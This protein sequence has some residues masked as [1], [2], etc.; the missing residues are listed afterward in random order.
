VYGTTGPT[1]IEDLRDPNPTT[2]AFLQAA[3]ELGWPPIE[4]NDPD[5]EGA[6][7]VRVTQHRGRRWSAADAYLEPARRR[8]NLRIITGAMAQRVV[9]TS[10]RAVGVEVARPGEGPMVVRAGAEVILAAGAVGSPHLLMRSGIGDPDE[11]RSLGIDVVAPRAEVGRNLQDHLLV[12]VV[13]RTPRPVSLVTAKSPRN[14]ARFL[15]RGRGPLT[16]N[17]GEALALLRTSPDEPAPDL[18]LIW[19]PVPFIDHGQVTP[20]G[21]GLTVGVALLQ[22]QSR[23]RITLGPS[24]AATPHIDPGYLTDPGGRDLATM[25]TGVRWARRV[26]AAAALRPWVGESVEPASTVGD[27]GEELAAFVRQ[28]A[29]TLYHPVGTC[30]MGTDADAVVDAQLRVRGVEG[31]RVVDA[32]VMPRITR[33]HTHAPTVMIAER[34]AAAITGRAIATEA[35]LTE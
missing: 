22:P 30:R 1:W 25:V 17:V 31:L 32:S 4:V 11:L 13:V 29:E 27:T 18:E 9:M 16:S 10:G 26:L 3:Q 35:A 15:V 33:G 21:H 7:P 23:G 19:A 34:A 8:P 6:G 5:A 20:D 28:Q 12:A 2:G 14:L 24:D